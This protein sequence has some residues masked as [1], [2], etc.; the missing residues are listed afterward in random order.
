MRNQWMHMSSLLVPVGGDESGVV[1]EGVGNHEEVADDLS[2]HV[3]SYN[4]PH[5]R[6]EGVRERGSESTYEGGHE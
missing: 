1:D 4:S 5:M 2:C 3:I 6:S